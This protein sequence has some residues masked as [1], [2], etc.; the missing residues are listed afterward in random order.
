LAYPAGKQACL[1]QKSGGL[2]ECGFLRGLALCKS[3]GGCWYWQL[4]GHVIRGAM[5]EPNNKLE[6]ESEV[7]QC[8]EI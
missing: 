8:V 5:P 1:E 4:Y 7:E 6:S 2:W 3:R